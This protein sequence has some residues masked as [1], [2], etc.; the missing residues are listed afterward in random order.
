MKY[1]VIALILVSCTKQA[2]QQLAPEDEV[3]QPKIPLDKELFNEAK[4]RQYKKTPKGWLNP[5][6]PH[7][8]PN[9]TTNPPPPPPP[10]T[11]NKTV[12]FLDFD[13]FGNMTFW[14]NPAVS[15]SGLTQEQ[16]AATVDEVKLNWK[17]FLDSVEITTDSTRFFSTPKGKRMRCVIT[18]DAW[19]G[20]VGGVAYV[21]SYHWLDDTP[22]WAFTSQLQFNPVYT[23]RA[24]S[25][26]LGHT[27]GLRH[28][29]LI[30]DGIITEYNPGGC[31]LAC[32]ECPIMGLPYYEP[33]ARWWVGYNSALQFQDDKQIINANL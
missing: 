17:I 3:G 4:D 33:L 19:Y 18:K 15:N 7:Y 6:N 28:Q 26:E 24:I 31:P 29:S 25:H 12:F 20:V 23:G 10:P 14:G 8:Q 27:V 1:L 22:C 11:A 32:G 5:N 9:D 13:G 30:V 21:N 2:R 16:I